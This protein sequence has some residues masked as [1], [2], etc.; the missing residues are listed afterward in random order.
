MKGTGYPYF[1][2]KTGLPDLPKFSWSRDWALLLNV[3]RHI[4]TL[5]DLSV[6][7]V[8]KFKPRHRQ[9]LGR[10]F[11]QIF[12]ADFSGLRR[13]GF[14]GGIACHQIGSSH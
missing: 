7:A 6:T 3:V 4:R 8:E 10:F 12:R 13:R 9:I 14:T 11:G 1:L 5:R 2:S